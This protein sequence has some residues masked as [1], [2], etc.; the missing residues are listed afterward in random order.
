ML[1]KFFFYT[2]AFFIFLIIFEIIFSIF[3]YFKSGFAGPIFK[4]F[5][6]E[7]K[8]TEEM[9]ME[10]IKIDPSTNKMVPGKFIIN[11]VNYSINSKGFRGNNFS[12]LNR[13]NCRII[14]L[15][16]SITL[17][18]EKS[19]PDLLGK[20]ILKKNDK[21]ESL[22]FGMGSK[23]LNYVEELFFNEVIGYEPNI[24]T[25]MA[26]RNATM[27]DSYGSGSK[28][29]GIIS[30]KKDYFIYRLNRFLFTNLMTFRFLDLSMKRI[31]FISSKDASKIVNP[32]N[33]GLLHSINYFKEK[34]HNQLANIANVSR[35]KDIKIV[36]IKEP[37]Y[38]DLKLQNEINKLSRKELLDKLTKYQK[39]DY[40]D[41]N[42]LFWAYTNALLN[43]IF[44]DIQKNYKN[45]LV[46]DPTILLYNEKKEKNF[47]ADGNH[48]TNNGHFIVAKEIYKKI[49][50]Y[51]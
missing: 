1:K 37:Y 10:S 24:I 14:S 32:T 12:D 22:N 28:S 6:K 45:V 21:C 41:K 2:I 38:L 51:F 9:I 3:F 46:V 25:I 8:T 23:G 33:E 36:L 20:M 35:E 4:L 50:K 16:G 44:D 43:S 13:N 34:Y 30:S 48:L 40:E 27:Y 49:E 39:E 5:L 11:G 7:T 18:V 31:I 19:Y 26:N 47:L 17:G 42:I 15:G 29:P